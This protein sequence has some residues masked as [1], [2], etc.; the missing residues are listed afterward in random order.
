MMN[1][2]DLSMPI[3]SLSDYAKGLGTVEIDRYKK[4]L[5]ISVKGEDILLPDPYTLKTSTIDPSR[6]PPVE[7]KSI[8]NYLIKT[9]GPYTGEALE[10]YKSLDAYNYFVSGH[11][12]QVE[13]CEVGESSPVVF[14]RACVTP[15]QK[16][17]NGPFKPWLCLDKKQ[18]YV[19]GSHC[20][21]MAGL[22]EAC[23]HIAALLFAVEAVTY[24]GVNALPP[25]TSVR[26][27]WSKYYKDQ[28]H[29]IS[30]RPS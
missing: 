26:C 2:N 3:P 10:A 25:G 7:Y 28:V 27:I 13:Q 12:K 20:T 14:V 8:Y 16:V 21:C 5:T 24:C 9:P 6:L 29:K 11:V 23:S 18:G 30:L 17:A 22:G 15:G 19:V 1:T 4:K